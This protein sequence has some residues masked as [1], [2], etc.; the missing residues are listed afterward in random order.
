M[1]A[2]VTFAQA[3]ITAQLDNHD[4]NEL[5]DELGRD[6]RTLALSSCRVVD[7]SAGF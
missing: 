1:C 4:E 5:I 7:V 2:A 6:P 3:S